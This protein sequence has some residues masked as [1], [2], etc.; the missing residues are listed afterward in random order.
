MNNFIQVQKFGIKE[1]HNFGTTLFGN[2]THLQK[3]DT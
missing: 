2:N 3:Y 1:Q